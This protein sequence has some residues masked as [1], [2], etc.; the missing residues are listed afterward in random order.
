MNHVTI[1]TKREAK[2]SHCKNYLEVEEQKLYVQKKQFGKSLN[3]M[4]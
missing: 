2:H 4:S 1:N 3:E